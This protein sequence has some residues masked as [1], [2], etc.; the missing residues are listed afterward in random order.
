MRQDTRIEGKLVEPEHA[1]SQ[2]RAGEI[3]TWAVFSEPSS[4]IDPFVQQ[5]ERL[6][7]TVMVHETPL[8]SFPWMEPEFGGFYRVYECFP[9]IFSRDAVH[10]GHVA[11]VPWPFGLTRADRSSDDRGRLYTRPDVYVTR[12]TEPDEDGY[13]SFGTF[14]WF[15]PDILKEARL[16]VGEID[17]NMVYTGARAPLSEIDYLVPA[18]SGR[19]DGQRAQ[20]ATP[21]AELQA[22]EVI[23]YLASEFIHDGEVFQVGIGPASEAMVGFLRDRHELGVHSEL[24]FSTIVELVRDGVITGARKKVD[25]EKVVTSGLY[26]HPDDPRLP[27]AMQFVSEN[28]DIFEFRPIGQVAN[29]K[30]V[31]E[32]ENIVAVNNILACD[33]T[34][35]VVVNTLGPK[36]ISGI[37][38]NFDFTVGTH[39]AVG[40][41]SLHCLLS[42]AKGGTVSRIVPE[43]PVGSVIS[44]PRTMVDY[45]VTE[46]GVVNLEGKSLRERAR[47]VISVAHPDFRG[48]LKAAA[49][50]LDLL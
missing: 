3:V 42:T 43:H 49:R 4:L 2:V 45:L 9:G 35:Q 15:A 8:M 46:Y 39:Y 47:A 28:S 29:V 5:R 31:A 16:V 17:P 1:V 40:G 27:A 22:A 13:V 19:S 25:R 12:V 24:I 36:P 14:P 11:Y 33:L 48:E 44:V 38:G 30:V 18:A 7:G 23:G 41:R 20:P 50:R 34:G 32:H 37:G 26:P 6:S 21:Q 10:A